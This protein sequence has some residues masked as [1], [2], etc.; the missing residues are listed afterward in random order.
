MLASRQYVEMRSA[1]LAL[2]K[3]VQVY[4]S[5]RPIADLVE[6]NIV[7]LKTDEDLKTLAQ[8]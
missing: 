4:P 8:R 2:T 5:Y 1:L 6:E 7:P 3:L